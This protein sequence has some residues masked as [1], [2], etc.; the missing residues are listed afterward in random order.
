MPEIVKP[1][2]AEPGPV[3]ESA[4]AAG[5]VGRVEGTTDRFGEDQAE[6]SSATRHDPASETAES[7]DVL[8]STAAHL[9]PVA[10]SRLKIPKTLAVEFGWSW[11]SAV[12]SRPLAP[13]AGCAGEPESLSE[14][15]QLFVL[16]GVWRSWVQA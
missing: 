12:R 13:C 7:R 15:G 14:C 9:L 16:A 4:E 3:E 2:A 11:W 6:R 8:L 1:G 5:E 10:S